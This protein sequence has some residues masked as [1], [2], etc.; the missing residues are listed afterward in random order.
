MIPKQDTPE[1]ID[2]R[3][4][5]N[6]KYPRLD[7]S[8]LRK[9]ITAVSL[10]VLTAVMLTICCFYQAKLVENGGAGI[11]PGFWVMI[12]FIGIW[13]VF[14]IVQVLRNTPKL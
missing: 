9:R 1:P 5:G 3:G 10:L 11:W 6:T 7:K 4:A 2:E 14:R 13:L 8:V 12:V